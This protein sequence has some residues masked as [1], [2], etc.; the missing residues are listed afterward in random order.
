[1]GGKSRDD[2]WCRRRP[3]EWDRSRRACVRNTLFPT[4]LRR[5]TFPWALVSR[6]A[7]RSPAPLRQSVFLGYGAWFRL[8][9]LGCILVNRAVARELSGT[10][11]IQNGFLRPGGAI[12]I[13]IPEPVLS[14]TIRPEIR[15]V[16]V[17]IAIGQQGIAYWGKSSR[18]VAAEIIRKDK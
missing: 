5:S 15:Q 18:F 9:D 11:H 3:T 6:P 1:R 17:V 12:G 14:L 13:K 10:G 2:H 7:A 16:H 8:P 4:E